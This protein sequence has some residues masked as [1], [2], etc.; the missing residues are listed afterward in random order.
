MVFQD[1]RQR[2][3]S[4]TIGYTNGNPSNI[5]EL[6]F[7]QGLGGFPAG[8]FGQV[9]AD[10]VEAVLVAGSPGEYVS[11]GFIYRLASDFS[12]WL[13]DP[14][15]SQQLAW[16]KGD[17]WFIIS[18]N[19]TPGHPG[20]MD[21][22]GLIAL[23]E[24]LVGAPPMSVQERLRPENLH[25][26]AEAEIL[27][28]FDLKAPGNLPDGVWLYQIQ[29]APRLPQLRLTYVSAAGS[30][31][32]ILEIPEAKF[33]LEKLVS[34]LPT[35][36]KVEIK[37]NDGWYVNRDVPSSSPVFL[38]GGAHEALFW[39]E[40]GIVYRILFFPDSETGDGIG[41]TGMVAIASSLAFVRK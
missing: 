22:Q 1:S 36:E 39:H 32:E 10:E 17:H 12:S 31:L 18:A 26:L 7:S 8:K 9:P 25:T 37:G 16:Q 30:L 20:Y 35:A 34:R 4:I 41:K 19:I 24:S 6:V 13:N 14:S 28:G 15:V 21:K 29:F 2:D 33:N 5:D 38:E 40:D 3:K 27:A 23:A 11:G